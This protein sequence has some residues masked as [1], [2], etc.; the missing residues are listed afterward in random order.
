MGVDMNYEFQKKSPKGWDRVNDNFSNDRSNYH[1][2]EEN[3]LC[4]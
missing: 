4:T 1:G 2:Y 3:A